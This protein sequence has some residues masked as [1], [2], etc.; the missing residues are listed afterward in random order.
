MSK[1]FSNFVAQRLFDFFTS[2]ATEILPGER[3]LLILDN[4]QTVEDVYEALRN[5]AQQHRALSNF[6]FRNYH[7]YSIRIPKT[8][9]VVAAKFNNLLTDDFLTTLRNEDLGD[10]HFPILILA[11]STIDSISSG[12]RNLASPGMPFDH[13]TIQD[14]VEKQIK[15][16]KKDTLLEAIL[17]KELETLEGDR[18]TD[19]TSLK[20]YEPLLSIFEYGAIQKE[21]YPKLGFFY[22]NDSVSPKEVKNEVNSN[23]DLFNLLKRLSSRYDYDLIKINFGKKIKTAVEQNQNAN[24]PWYF[25]L[26]YEDVKKGYD[27]AHDDSNTAPEII[28]DSIR[29]SA[30]DGSPLTLDTLKYEVNRKKANLF[31]F[32]PDG[33][34]SVTMNFETTKKNL[35]FECR[36]DKYAKPNCQKKSVSWVLEAEGCSIYS[37]KIKESKAGLTELKICILNLPSTFLPV[38]DQ[39]YDLKVAKQEKNCVI[40]VGIDKD[41]FLL[42]ESGTTQK[43]FKYNDSKDCAKNEY[44]IT[45]GD[46]L[47]IRFDE[48]ELLERTI[49][50]NIKIGLI[51]IPFSIKGQKQTVKELDGKGVLLK[52]LTEKQSLVYSGSAL[53]MGNEKFRVKSGTSF[54]DSLLFEQ[55]FLNKNLIIARLEDTLRSTLEKDS[56]LE[57]LLDPKV[58][59]AYLEVLKQF[60]QKQTL[61]SLA[62]YSGDL[63]AAIQNFAAVF[64]QA[65][66]DIQS[67]NSLKEKE[68]A[69]LYI[70]SILDP[71][72]NKV[73]FTPLSPLNLMYQLQL[74]GNV[75]GP[76]ENR[77][78]EMLT[79]QNL[80]PYLKAPMVSVNKNL[81]YAIVE[82]DHSPEWRHYS[83]KEVTES[84]ISRSYVKTIVKNKINQ[85]RDHFPFLFKAP[86]SKTM[87]INLIHM[88]NCEDVFD[89]IIAYY[90]DN[91]KADR[92]PDQLLQFSI[93]IYKM[94]LLD[95]T[96][97]ERLMNS[98]KLEKYLEEHVSEKKIEIVELASI[99]NRKLKI[100]NIEYNEK[101]TEPFRYAHLSFIE[102]KADPL[103][104]TQEIE[105]MPTGMAVGGLISGVSSA[106]KADNVWYTS[107]FGMKYA[108]K[109]DFTRTVAKLNAA[110][111]VVGTASDFSPSTCLNTQI[112]A[113]Q[114]Y[115]LKNLYESSNWV[116]FINPKVDLSFFENPEVADNLM[117]IHYS[118]QLSPASGYDDITVTAK[119]Q[120]YEERIQEYL[121]DSGAE[122]SR[123]N[124][125]SIIQLFN[126]VNGDWL[127]RMNAENYIDTRSYFSKEKMSILSA[128]RMLLLYTANPDVIWVPMS[129]EEILRVSGSVGL[130]QKDGRL[131]ARN[132]G[133]ENQNPTCDDIL[134]VGFYASSPDQPLQIVFHPVE[135]KIGV[136][137]N[138]VITKAKVQCKNTLEGLKRTIFPD[139]P[140]TLAAK[141]LQTFF[142]QQVLLA[143]EKIKVFAIFPHTNWDNLIKKWREK[144]LNNDVIYCPQLN[145]SMGQASIIS[146]KKDFGKGVLEQVKEDDVDIDLLTLPANTGVKYLTESYEVM[147]KELLS[148]NLL[149]DLTMKKSACT[150]QPE[151]Q[152][153]D[154]FDHRLPD[155]VCEPISKSEE[156]LPKVNLYEL[157][158]QPNPASSQSVPT[159]YYE[160]SPLDHNV[161]VPKNLS[162]EKSGSVQTNH[163]STPY[164][165]TAADQD[166]CPDTS[167]AGQPVQEENSPIY[168]KPSYMEILFGTNVV[169]NQPVYWHPNNSEMVVNLNTGVIG[170]SGT[171]K[172]QFVKSLIAQLSMQKSRNFN[173]DDF[174]ILIFDYKGD[175]NETKKDFYDLLKPTVLRLEDLPVN[176]FSLEGAKSGM[177]RIPMHRAR[178]FVDTIS[179]AYNLGK[180]QQKNLKDVIMQAYEARGINSLDPSTWSKLPPTL[181]DVYRKYV[182]NEDIKKGD[183]LEAALE[184]LEDFGIFESDPL[185]AKTLYNLVKGVVVVDL[186]TSD[187]VSIRNLVV[188]V[189]LDLF[190]QQMLA[191]GSSKIDGKYREL[192]KL[193]LVDEADNFMSQDFSSLKKILKEGREFGVGMILS[194]Q[195]LNHFDYG[196]DNYA[197]YINTWI[198][199]EFKGAKP[200]EMDIVFGTAKADARQERLEQIS[201]LQK[202]HSIVKIGTERPQ[203]I[204][205]YSFY[206][207]MQNIK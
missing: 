119:I 153:E 122:I 76:L 9:L 33:L 75:C 149:P 19:K 57:N 82:Q 87:N 124:I 193:I 191:K 128:V 16:Y 127:L 125:G 63:L 102:M 178:G 189:M 98:E 100:Y 54:K 36:P 80:I 139:D 2:P 204:R 73:F 81:N 1:T 59:E 106:M 131:S 115:L 150:L 137:D 42:N 206:L 179:K 166:S 202:F 111:S 185:K 97:F 7:T 53:F 91:L 64:K 177:S 148:W 175:Y 94:S 113:K 207:L 188:A 47:Q 43:S 142:L 182:N 159:V 52:K 92:D 72:N 85:Y 157:S 48:S 132:L 86:G 190:Y 140:D 161:S 135:V 155:S 51:T 186:T 183:S 109:T 164:S 38:R 29:F 35:T 27:S 4:E 129:L 101:K 173:N 37:F 195:Y 21:E 8:Q 160:T 169:N 70:G 145:G 34:D 24:L 205:D 105:S 138:A 197:K 144:L 181:S 56:C 89:G 107:G 165:L 104:G 130:S 168:S 32:N 78:V 196:E 201:H 133:F 151:T 13:Q 39:N 163:T 30:S 55:A 116:V 15:Q 200:A 143:A 95:E 69:L 174:G 18:Y 11:E 77:F 123:Q 26:S 99:L 198:I 136:N 40:L 96:V 10:A 83:E 154:V 194:T 108:P 62:Y 152:H 79:P 176:P 67:H 14:Y 147:Y 50:L 141:L 180:V 74:Q 45:S 103:I 41:S 156:I 6:S 23:A 58:K 114:D 126:A 117:I 90:T 71:V 17:K 184:E 28:L 49:K 158:S 84:L 167:P 134:L 60:R 146:F 68:N 162:V 192:T 31:I 3:F 65:M 22:F 170:T 5:T 46:R 66:N 203:I 118:D 112:N 187:S 61:P 12:T 110:Y 88:G 44:Q 20:E 199:H 93:N 172:T 25:G 120:Q 121:K 171:G